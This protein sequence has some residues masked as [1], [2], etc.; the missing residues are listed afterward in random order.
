MARTPTAAGIVLVYDKRRH[1]PPLTYS[2]AVGQGQGY[3][4]E[5]TTDSN[6]IYVL[7]GRMHNAGLV[8]DYVGIA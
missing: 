7:S 1:A 4:R 8:L 6:P 5:P 3:H 2:T